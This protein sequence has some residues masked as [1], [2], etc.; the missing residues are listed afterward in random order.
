MPVFNKLTET[1]TASNLTPF[2]GYTPYSCST[3]CCSASKTTIT[4]AYNSSVKRKE[5]RQI[6]EAK[7]NSLDATTTQ[8]NSANSSP[9]LPNISSTC[10]NM[11]LCSNQVFNTLNSDG[12]PT[13]DPT[14]S[15]PNVNNVLMN[16]SNPTVKAVNHTYKSARSTRIAKLKNTSFNK[17]RPR[18]NTHPIP[19]DINDV[20]SSGQ[21]EHQI[22]HQI[23]GIS[24]DYVDEGDMSFECEACG[25]YLWYKETR[26]G[27]NTKGIPGSFSLCCMKGK[28]ELPEFTKN[29]PKL[30]WDLYNNNHPKSK[31]FIENV[32]QYNMVFSFTS[33]GG[34]VD[35]TA[36]R[37]RGPYTF[38]IRG[39]NYHRMGG[40]V[41]STGSSPKYSQLYIYDTTN[42]ATNRK[43]A[44]GGKNLNQPTTLRTTLDEDLIR[45]LMVMLDECNP[46]VKIYRR[47]RDFF[48]QN[49]DPNFKIKLIARR[50]GDG[51]NYNLPTVD[52]VAALI[53]RDID[54]NFDKRD[55]IID[56]V[57]EGLQHINELHSQYLAL[58]YP[59]L[60]SHAEDG[61]RTDIYHSDVDENTTRLKKRIT[62]REFFAY[63]LQER[64]SPTLVHIAQIYT[65]EFQKRGLRHAHICIFLDE[66]DK[67][68]EPEDV[69]K[70]ISAEIPDKDDDPERYQL[71]SDLMIH[72]PC[73]DK[74]PTCPCT[75]IEKKCTKN[76]PK[77]Y[78]DCTTVDKDGYPIYK[79]TDNGRTVRKLGH[80]LDNGSVVPYNPVLLK[81]YQAHINVEWCNQL[82]A[83][84]YL[85]KYINKGNDRVTAGVCDEVTDEIK[86][87][88]DCRYVSSCKTVWRMLGF[89]I[90]NRNPIVIRLA[91][92]LPDHMKKI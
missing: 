27:K 44:I 25:A 68:P 35:K 43:A 15:A 22:K 19:F 80:D 1:S 61:Y 56:S 84:R 74:N 28:I 14:T 11:S 37:G 53:V 89:D 55:I 9:S 67:L 29:P 62:M 58:Q 69:D 8:Q 46:L 38:R 82:G 75:Y 63:K 41:P 3:S 92:H 49:N 71:V 34:N 48:E 13:P 21:N 32:R 90:H 60:F 91:F 76:F 12:N 88:Y 64:K 57:K 5:R 86:E 78:A 85:F 10:Q 2:N 70:F 47:A 39:Q 23:K 81:K 79:R 20:G 18:N 83:I 66:K 17:T 36:N 24:E 51:C 16:N 26:R 50:S 54:L 73:G 33:M 72:G 6:I 42:E 45:D 52:E 87:Y 4:G 77:P 31:H 30:L 59:L 65:I 7:R 40:L